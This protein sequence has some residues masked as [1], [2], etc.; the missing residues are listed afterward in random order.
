MMINFCHVI[1]QV[2]ANI[3]AQMDTATLLPQFGFGG[4]VVWVVVSWLKKIEVSLENLNH[5]VR[6][7]SKAIYLDLAERAQPGSFVREE[8][9]RMVEKEKA[10]EK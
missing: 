7:L 8:A 1:A 10:R 2:A 3:V 5:T 6:G 4:L 9:K